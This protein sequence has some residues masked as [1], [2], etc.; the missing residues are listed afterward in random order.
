MFIEPKFLKKSL[1]RRSVMGALKVRYAPLE[2][3]TLSFV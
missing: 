3:M 1:L 2:L